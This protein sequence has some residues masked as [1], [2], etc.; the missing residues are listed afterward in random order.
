MRLRI[1]TVVAVVF[2][3]ACV[4]KTEGALFPTNLTS[5][6]PFNGIAYVPFRGNESPNYYTYPSIADVTDDITNK[7]VYLASEIATY[8]MAGSQFNI[9]AICNTY[10]L[11]CYPC[12]FLNVSNSYDNSNELNALILVGNQNYPTTRGL[13]VG[14]EA[15]RDGYDVNT[16]ISN[17]NYI[18]YATH[19]TVPIGT[20]E[21]PSS[22]FDHPD[23]VAACDFIQADIFPYWAGT[24]ADQ[25]ASFTIQT[26][27][28]L[29][30]SFPGTKV[31]IGETGW[32]TAGTNIWWGSS[33]T[34]V[35]SVANQEVYLKAFVPMARSMGV[36]YFI[37]E[38]RDQ[39]WQAQEGIGNVE[40]NWGIYYG[41][42]TKKQ[43]L[44][45]YLRSGFSV[46]ISKVNASNADIVV[47]T[48]EGNPYSIV[49]TPDIR[50]GPWTP[51]PF[52]GAAGT[53]QTVITVPIFTNAPLSWFYFGW[54]NF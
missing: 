47:P 36:E 30:N 2:V 15:I 10:N 52:T 42:N 32:P 28:Q 50:V 8:G 33:S 35:P 37:F 14:S 24:P 27:Q 40:T 31:I 11:P 26:W 45:D 39:S 4:A 43:S 46:Q 22:F 13:I 16:L 25:G 12:A 20:R 21:P 44:V 34:I 29:T 54:Q 3:M 19:G 7:L 9:A 23:L 38:L 48:F 17:I 6:K 18:R 51:Y 41:D 49:A 53:N 5:F 1:V